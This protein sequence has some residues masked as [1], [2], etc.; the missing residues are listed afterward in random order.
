MGDSM[1]E[2]LGE[3]GAAMDRLW[4]V[5]DYLNNAPCG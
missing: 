3:Y 4:R 2:V 1:Q 5:Y